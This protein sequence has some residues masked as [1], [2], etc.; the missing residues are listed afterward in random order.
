M[1]LSSG[2]PPC[3]SCHKP[4]GVRTPGV[5][6]CVET[7]R[8]FW[9]NRGLCRL[10]R[11]S[12][13]TEGPLMTAVLGRVAK[14]LDLF[15]H[16]GCSC[17]SRFPID[18]KRGRAKAFPSAACFCCISRIFR[19]LLS[20]LMHDHCFFFFQ[21]LFPFEKNESVQ[22]HRTV[23]HTAVNPMNSHLGSAHPQAARCLFS[24][25]LWTWRLL[26]R[27]P[28]LATMHFYAQLWPAS[29]AYSVSLRSPRDPFSK[30]KM[31][32]APNT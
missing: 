20:S 27:F 17:V 30:S 22:G 32:S 25:F 28:G 18:R 2:Y 7:R 14:V 19:V 8:C 23:Q 15:P 1:D 29:L 16:W 13:D 9:P 12:I 6:R 3:L 26:P 4:G 21:F 24:S 5:C 31:R 10:A 11:G